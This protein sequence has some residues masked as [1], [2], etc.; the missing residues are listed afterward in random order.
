MRD[1]A[2]FDVDRASSSSSLADGILSAPIL[3]G[4]NAGQHPLQDNIAELVA[5]S[6]MLDRS[7]R[8]LRLAISRPDPR[9]T[10]PN[11]P[12]TERHLP[13]LMAM[14]DRDTIRVVLTLRADDLLD[15]GLK[16]LPK[17]PQPDLDRQRQQSL[18]R[19]PNQL[20]ERLLHPLREHGLTTD[21]LSDRYVAL[22]GGSS[23]DLGRIARHAPT[24]SGRAGGTAVTSKFYEP[25]D[26]LSR[27]GPHEV[28]VNA[29]VKVSSKRDRARPHHLIGDIT[30][31]AMGV[32][33]LG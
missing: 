21:R 3:P 28:E 33:S 22:H 9:P 11:T 19:R 30:P 7:Q 24:T 2:D 12:A 25:R 16:Q 6:E 1:T 4:R 14:T 17:H 8:H 10:D 23:F 32:A 26:N 20:P 29:E 31:I 27:I 15:L 13:I 18:S 5:L